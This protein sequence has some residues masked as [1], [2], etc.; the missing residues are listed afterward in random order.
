MR[1]AAPKARKPENKRS[2]RNGPPRFEGPL[3]LEKKAR[4]RAPRGPPPR[5]GLT[6]RHD[7]APG[8]V[9]IASGWVIEEVGKKS[10][11]S[12]PRKIRMRGRRVWPAWLTGT[13]CHVQD[14]VRACH[15]P[16]YYKLL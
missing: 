11:D 16:R 9:W 14:H 4:G 7:P 12:G 5:F 15:T 2:L 13:W 8:I 10:P 1:G 6:V 3:M